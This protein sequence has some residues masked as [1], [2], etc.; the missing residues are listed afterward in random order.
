ML[1]LIETKPEDAL[2]V[3]QGR[4][5]QRTSITDT[6]AL[7]IAK[8]L[9]VSFKRT[10]RAEEHDVNDVEADELE[11]QNHLMYVD[12]WDFASEHALAREYVVSASDVISVV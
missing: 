3:Q 11:S 2:D 9:A 1:T 12:G 8:D 6:K 4:R 10:A 7:T 5:R